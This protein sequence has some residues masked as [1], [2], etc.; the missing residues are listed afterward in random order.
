MKSESWRKYLS[1]SY[2]DQPVDH[3]VPIP[4]L[5]VGEEPEGE[6]LNRNPKKGPQSQLPIVD[7]LIDYSAVIFEPQRLETIKTNKV[8]PRQLMV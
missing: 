8:K 3:L 4:K 5:I 7:Q 1:L 2:V 6:R